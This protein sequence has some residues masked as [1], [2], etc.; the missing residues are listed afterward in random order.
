MS[1]S[2]LLT[3]ALAVLALGAGAM[4]YAATGERPERMRTGATPVVPQSSDPDRPALRAADLTVER[5]P[6]EPLAALLLRSGIG[7]LDSVLASEGADAGSGSVQLWLGEQVGPGARALE[8]VALHRGPGRQ[9]II[10]RQGDGFTRRDLVEAVDATPVRIR[11]E[12]G[13]GLAAG[14]VEA[15]L[16]RDVR[17]RLLDRVAGERLAAIDL[18]IAHQSAASGS[19]YGEPLYLGAYEVDGTMRRWVGGGLRPLGGEEAASGGLLRPLPGAV[20]SNPGLRFHPILRYLR[21]HRG[22][23]FAS[24][25][26]TP[27][28]AAL[29]GRV[30]SAGWQG[31]YGRAVRIAHGDGSTTLYAHLSEIDVIGGQRVP[32]G[33]VVGKVGSSGL[34]TG[35][36]L[37]FEW[38]RSGA[39]LRPSFGQVAPEGA[40]PAQR[41]ALQALLSAPFRLAPDRRS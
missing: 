6:G 20:T 30:V 3:S 35:P 37:H 36:H 31:G 5:R 15:G 29:E 4:G 17:D 24:P 23:D 19:S 2:A 16:P 26:G 40:G 38:Q 41:A 21:W 28:Q 33:A 27:V 22:T 12:G 10:E 11:L 25:A 34:A 39:T 14:L 9:T 1:Q 18:I 8:R 13:A 32:R 7:G